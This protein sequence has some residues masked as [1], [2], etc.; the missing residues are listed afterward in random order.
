[1]F[2]GENVNPSANNFN[3]SI[4]GI[5]TYND[6]GYRL[7]YPDSKMIQFWGGYTIYNGDT[8]SY[9]ALRPAGLTSTGN[10]INMSTAI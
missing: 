8:A 6:P 4:Y 9:M 10:L 3:W 7:Y 2:T 1:M 5:Q